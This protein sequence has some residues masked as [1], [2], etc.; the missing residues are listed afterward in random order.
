MWWQLALVGFWLWCG[1]VQAQPSR[2]SPPSSPVVLDARAGVIPL[3]GRMAWLRDPQGRLQHAEQAEA[4]TGW[5]PLPGSPNLGFTPDALWLRWDV[6]QPDGGT[7]WRLEV[8]NTLLEDVRLYQRD[9][10]GAWQATQSGRVVTHSAWPLD[11]RSPVFRLDLEPGTHALMLRLQTRNSLS[12]SVKLWESER[13]YAS[14]QDEALLWGI[15]F[16]LYALVILIQFLF[17]KWTREVLSGWYVMYAGLN[18]LG[19]MLSMGY[20]QNALDWSGTL[21][22]VPLS[23]VICASIYAGTQFS[24]AALELHRHMPRVRRFLTRGAAAVALVTS[25]MVLAGAH[26]AGVGAAQVLSIVWMLLMAGVA[27]VP[28]RRGEMAGRFLLVAFGIFFLG[29]LVRYLRNLGW[30]QPGPLTDYS[31]QVASVLH[32][33]VMCMFIVY[34]YN[35]L[36]V[37]LQIE[38]AAR[39]EQRDFVALVSHEFR[40][41]LAIIDT[42]AQQ[43]ATHL[44]APAERSLQRCANIRDATRRMVDLMDNCLTAERM[45]LAEPS[46]HEQACDL[47][48]LLQDLV[49]EWPQGRVVVDLQQL[50]DVFVCDPDMLRVALRNLVANADRHARADMPVSLRVKGLSGGA[51]SLSVRNTGDAIAPDELP[52][53]FQRYY[54][55]RAARGKPGAGLGLFLVQRIVGAHGGHVSVRSHLGVTTFKVWLP[56]RSGA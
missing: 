9:E 41:P 31:I 15:Y 30:L 6:R 23:L 26:R 40:T 34:R 17:W 42:S 8:D 3:A 35:A 22:L 2:L 38:Q 4:E 46:V 12:T 33:V 29:I 45:D 51:L 7:S 11:T 50:P 14:A 55:G 48:A 1:V 18:C 24:S 49:A 44:D 56:A 36:R 21:A 43:L 47:R 37:A 16:G 28:L 20:L 53:L 19:M 32:M 54:R 52:L 39:R 5:A 13:F 10:T 25:A 27:I